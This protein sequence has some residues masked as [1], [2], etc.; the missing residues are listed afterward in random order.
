MEITMPFDIEDLKTKEMYV[1]RMRLSDDMQQTLAALTG[2]DTVSRK[3]LKCSTGGILYSTSP[4]LAA[5]AT[6]EANSDNYAWQGVAKKTSEIMLK[7]DKTNTGIVRVMV[8]TI[9]GLTLGWPLNANDVVGFSIDNLHNLY[10]FVET[11]GEKVTI[12]YTR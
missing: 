11:N 5:I 12:A 1:G 6:I 7:A 10:I 2:Y 3:L 9:A 8:D 4:R